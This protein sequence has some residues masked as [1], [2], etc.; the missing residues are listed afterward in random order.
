MF[1]IPTTLTTSILFE[2]KDGGGEFNKRQQPFKFMSHAGHAQPTTEV[3]ELDDDVL[4]NIGSG[5]WWQ[6][7]TGGRPDSG[8]VVMHQWWGLLEV[9]G[10]S[11]VWKFDSILTPVMQ[12]GQYTVELTSLNN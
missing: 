10:A 6:Q 5:H 8:Q 2:I 12:G 9:Y 4:F 11:G 3:T 1:P 7:Q